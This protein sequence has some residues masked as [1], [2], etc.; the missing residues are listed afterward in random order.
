MGWDQETSSGFVTSLL[1]DLGRG[2][3]HLWA[4]V[5]LYVK[6]KYSSSLKPSL[7]WNFDS[8]SSYQN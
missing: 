1:G 8:G 4:S 5:T 2:S 3:S 7:S 6:R